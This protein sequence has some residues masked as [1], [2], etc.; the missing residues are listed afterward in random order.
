VLQLTSKIKAIMNEKLYAYAFGTF[1]IQEKVNVF[2]V[3]IITRFSKINLWS[4]QWHPILRW[5][6]VV[7]HSK[8]LCIN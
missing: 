6:N 1:H 5:T 7:A 2:N 8:T 3:K 4:K